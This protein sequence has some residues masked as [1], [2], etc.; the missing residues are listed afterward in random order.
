MYSIKKLQ[1]SVF[2]LF[3]LLFCCINA[4]AQTET[5]L[6][7]GDKFSTEYENEEG[8]G[9]VS[10]L[11][12]QM[13]ES[14]LK[15]Q[16]INAS[17]DGETTESGNIH[18]PGLLEKHSPKILI[19][20]LGWNDGQR[21]F[22]VSLIKTNLRSMIKSALK[23]ECEVLVLGVRI[24]P[25]FHGKVYA[26]QFSDLYLQLTNETNVELVPFLLDDPLRERV[27][28]VTCKKALKGC[29]TLLLDSVWPHLQP[30]LNKK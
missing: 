10:L 26:E 28:S 18:L 1:S 5:I 13:L 30:L 23:A 16:V 9:W 27:R 25:K 21:G 4:N 22:P 14:G 20:G 7:L 6:V 3:F 11:E 24:P 12:K 8:G 2:L 17:I 19:I 29:Q 15:Y